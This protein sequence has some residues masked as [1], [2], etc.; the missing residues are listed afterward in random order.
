MGFWKF[1]PFLV[2]SILVLYQAGMFH[3]APVRLPLESSFDSATLTEEE[4]SLLLVAMVKDYVQMKAT[5]L[6]QES[7]DFSITAQEKSCNTASCVTHKMTGWLSRSGS[8]A[9]NNFMPTNV[10]SKILG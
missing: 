3:T 7:E 9:K 2:L 6:E 1:P 4:V 8:V 10:D 5:V